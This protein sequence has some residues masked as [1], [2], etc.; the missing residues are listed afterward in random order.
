M[1]DIARNFLIDL[2]AISSHLRI[3]VFN[4]KKSHMFDIVKATGLTVE[5]IE[6]VLVKALESDFRDQQ[7][8]L[9]SSQIIFSDSQERARKPSEAMLY[10]APYPP[11][12][13][14]AA[15]TGSHIEHLRNYHSNPLSR[16]MIRAFMDAQFTQPVFEWVQSNI[17]NAIDIGLEEFQEGPT[18]IGR[19]IGMT[20]EKVKELI[21]RS[22][23]I[24]PDQV[25]IQT[26]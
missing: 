10:E 9:L 26:M 15:L 23:G 7:L 13:I 21:S 14:V 18:H 25:N 20:T 24:R 8:E 5:R 12:R 2:V 4:G 1:R 17:D 16:S 19:G 22:M 3:A 11:L 6:D